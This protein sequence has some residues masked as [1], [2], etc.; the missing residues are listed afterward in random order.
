[1]KRC[2]F[3]KIAA[4]EYLSMI[5]Y[6]K[7]RKIEGSTLHVTNVKQGNDFQVQGR[8]LVEKELSSAAQFETEEKL[9][10]TELAEK[11]TRCG[12]S[13]FTVT[14]TKADGTERTLIGHFLHTEPLLGRSYVIDLEV[15][16]QR[17]VDHRTIK[18]LIVQ[19]VK[20]VLK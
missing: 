11:F 4:D 16:A 20:Y 13:V 14:F 1:M 5:T 12:D 19:N 17:L 8:E 15:N 7:V 6:V 10:A 18:S 9:T 2:Q 3:E